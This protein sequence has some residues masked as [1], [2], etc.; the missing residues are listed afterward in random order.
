MRLEGIMSRDVKTVS[1]SEPAARAYEI[2][3]MRHIH[4]L[5]VVEQGKIVGILSERDLGGPRGAALRKSHRVSELMTP[6]VICGKLD[7]TVRQAANLLRGRSFGCL[8]VVDNG[9]LRGIVTT[10]DLLEL[11]G[12]G[13]ER[14]VDRG[15]RWTLKHRGQKPGQALPR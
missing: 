2:M 13:I 7:T 11:L 3:R 10:S 1:T 15:R 12:R 4:H 8:P 9:K 5:V 6:Q 14:P